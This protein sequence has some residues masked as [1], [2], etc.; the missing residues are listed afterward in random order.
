MNAKF[1][2]VFWGS[3]LGLHLLRYLLGD[4]QFFDR[5]ALES[6]FWLSYGPYVFLAFVLCDIGHSAIEKGKKKKRV[7]TSQNGDGPA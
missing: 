2:P 4:E 6:K 1:Y 7:P 5:R 3:Y